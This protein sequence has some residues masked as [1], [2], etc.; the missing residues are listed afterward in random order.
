[1]L[2]EEPNKR[3][4]KGILIII[5]ELELIQDLKINGHHPNIKI[6]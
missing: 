1:M 4:L 6:A 3:I 2:P 5:K